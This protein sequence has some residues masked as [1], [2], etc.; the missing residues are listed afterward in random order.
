M[1]LLK[2]SGLKQRKLWF[3][4]SQDSWS[5]LAG[6]VLGWRLSWGCSQAVP[7]CICPLKAWLGLRNSLP[8]WWLFTW[9]VNW[10][11][12]L[13][14]IFNFSLCGLLHRL[15][16]CPYNRAA[17]SRVGNPGEQNR[18]CSAFYDLVLAILHCCF[19]QIL[20]VRTQSL[21]IVHIQG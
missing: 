16:E 4:V 8:W 15:L 14:V 17:F 5:G 11:W 2:L 13:V 12:L 6:V 20:F 19:C 18:S 9:L 7:W 1:T 3:S 10:C 21:G